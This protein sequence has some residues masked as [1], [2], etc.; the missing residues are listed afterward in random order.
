MI[1]RILL[2]FFTFVSLTSVAE[3]QFPVGFRPGLYYSNPVTGNRFGIAYYSGASF[4][5]GYTNPITGVPSYAVIGYQYAGPVNPIALRA[6]SLGAY[7]YANSQ[8]IGGVN[9][10]TSTDPASN[11][12]VQEQLR[13]LRAAGGQRGGNDIEARKLIV[14]QRA[15]EGRNQFERPDPN[16]QT[17]LDADIISGQALNAVL[18]EIHLAHK[19]SRKADSPLLPGQMLANV[20]Y[21]TS[22]ASEIVNLMQLGKNPWP[23][24]LNVPE[25]T[26]VRMG[27][28][29]ALLPAL[30]A[31]Q[32]GKKLTPEQGHALQTEVSKAKTQTASLI[33][34]V[35]LEEAGE[36]L[37]FWSQL[38]HLAKSASQEKLQGAY[39]PTWISIGATVTEL[40][41]HMDKY[42]MKFG[43]APKGEEEAYFALHRAM[44]TYHRALTATK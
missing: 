3:A 44:A 10:M 4:G 29:R 41:K 9:S 12:I 13:L 8:L 14:D 31:T 37:R 43:P 16:A 5:A 36:V 6:A 15:K 19:A 30:E 27:V 32:A 40:T 11:P 24:A 26:S 22:A 42:G 2:S 35:S 34:E 1:R 23:A 7:Q 33:N 17:I 21:D 20:S 38:E 18:K 39:N 25:W 28:D